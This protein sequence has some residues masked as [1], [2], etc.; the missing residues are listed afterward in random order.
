MLLNFVLISLILLIK[1]EDKIIEQIYYITKKGYTI[2]Y[3][4]G[5]P[6]Q[7]MEKS[8]DQALSYTWT[9]PIFFRPNNSQT[10]RRGPIKELNL[11]HS[12]TFAFFIGALYIDRIY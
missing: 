2:T 12:D 7:Y 1:A 9:T 3:D 8:I 11:L 4:V 5:E 10:L 6:R